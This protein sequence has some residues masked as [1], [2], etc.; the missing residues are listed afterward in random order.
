MTTAFSLRPLERIPPGTLLEGAFRVH[1]ALKDLKALKL[2][3]GDLVRLSTPDGPKG[4]AIAWLASQTNPGNKPIAKVTDLLRDKYGLSLNDR[5]FVEKADEEWKPLA[6]V[7]LS[8]SQPLESLSG[9]ASTEEL[10]FWTR[11]ALGATYP[12][13]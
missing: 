13:H 2:S 11:C 9:Y 3:N 5:V 7:E 8:F 1:L 12:G 6:S 10:M 4:I